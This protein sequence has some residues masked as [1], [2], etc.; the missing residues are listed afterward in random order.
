MNLAYVIEDS[1]G[2]P[3]VAWI[4]ETVPIT[5]EEALRPQ[6]AASINGEQAD[7]RHECDGWLRSLLAEGLK[8][9]NEVFKAGN[10]AGFTKDQIRRAKYRIGAV[11]KKEGFDDDAQWSW[12]LP[13]SASG[14]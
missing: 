13:A 14:D 1:G 4:D 5:V 11:A 6:M 8:S 7:E 10:A 3:R 12:E 9:S 2:G